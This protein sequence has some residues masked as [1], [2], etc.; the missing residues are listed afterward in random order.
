MYQAT[1]R[2]LLGS[3]AVWLLLTSGAA[4]AAI[5]RGGIPWKPGAGGPPEQVTPGGWKF[6]TPQE[7]AAVEALV[8]RLIPADELSPGGKECG[9]AVFIDRQLAGPYGHFGGYYMAG[10]FQKGTKQQGPQSPVTPAEQY[11]KALAALDQ[12]CRGKYGGKAFAE[13]TDA[14][15][16]EVIGGLEGGSFNL[17][18]E[19]GQEFFKLVLKNTQNGYLADPI[20]GGNK[21]MASWKMIG[22]PGAHYDYRDW[23]NKHNQRV[24][25]ASV[26]IANHPNWTQQHS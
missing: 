22:F 5:I 23:I 26:G 10:P 14:Q 2:Q 1:R 25:L 7:A 19:D 8:D 20:Y 11:R 9:C 4:R 24:T 16:D 3:S 13:L 12:A 21:D 17:G 6:F 18:G 15:K